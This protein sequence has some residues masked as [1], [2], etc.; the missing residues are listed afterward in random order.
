MFDLDD[1]T[2]NIYS[3]YRYKTSFI[4]RITIL[5]CLDPIFHVLQ[6]K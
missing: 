6:A 2:R 1:P 5:R 4:S 3:T